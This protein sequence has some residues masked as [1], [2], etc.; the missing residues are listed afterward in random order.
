MTD[1]ADT[2]N[3]VPRDSVDYFHRHIDALG[4]IVAADVRDCGD[5]WP[6][7]YHLFLYDRAGNQLSLSGCAAGAYG[8]PAYQA[9]RVLVEAG[10]DSTQAARAL[11]EAPLRLSRS[12]TI[13]RGAPGVA[14]SR[15]RPIAWGG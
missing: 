3:G 15:R 11:V 10:F 14:H 9:T 1:Y 5:G 2:G 7:P 6:N 12:R 4:T 8:E 13:R